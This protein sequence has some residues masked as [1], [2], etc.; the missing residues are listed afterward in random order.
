MSAVLHAQ[1][2]PRQGE[3]LQFSYS[4]LM[5]LNKPAE[6]KEKWNSNAWQLQLM[7]ETY[8]RAGS[9]FSL[10]Y[11]LGISNYYYHNNLRISTNPN[12][13]DLNYSWLTDTT[14]KTNRFSAS[15]IDIPI[16][17]R[18]RSNTNKY[19]RYYRF[20]VGALVGY[21]INSFSHFKNGDYSV[22]HYRINDLARWHYGVYMRT[23][24]WIFNIFAYYGI[25]PTFDST[26]A[27]WEALKDIH[28]LQLGV[29]ISL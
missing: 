21:R 2:V 9:H 3:W 7:N 14:Y 18:Y 4:Y 20:Y 23:G 26:P 27:G 13:G 5:M 10:G 11:G 6:L 17:F 29:S 15:Y 8:L 12:G 28:S 25:N 22:K 1:Y 16:E 19:G 24:F